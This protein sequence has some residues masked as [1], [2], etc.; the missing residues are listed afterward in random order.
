M[1]CCRSK[2]SEAKPSDHRTRLVLNGIIVALLILN[3]F[4]LSTLYASSL[5]VRDNSYK[6]PDNAKRCLRDAVEHLLVTNFIEFY[7]MVEFIVDNTPTDD[8]GHQIVRGNVDP[9]KQAKDQIMAAMN[10]LRDNL[11]SF[12]HD[13][14]SFLNNAKDATDDPS[15]VGAWVRPKSMLVVRTL[16]GASTTTSDPLAGV[17]LKAI[18]DALV[19][20]SS[21]VFL[22]MA[23]ILTIV[24]ALFAV[25][26]LFGIF[27]KLPTDSGGGCCQKSYGSWPF[28]GS[29]V[30]CVLFMTLFAIATGIL[31][32]VGGGI[33]FYVCEP[34][35]EPLARDDIIQ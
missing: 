15:D 11:Q 21:W 6:L 31:M 28:R 18:Y 33:R 17:D 12:F 23:I 9:D 16:D 27:G 8:K 35:E 4:C 2:S 19:K 14:D 26:V 3:T 29:I 1:L 30:V 32:H 24:T 10:E 34:L 7:N 5:D 13:I 22:T 20:I 25:G